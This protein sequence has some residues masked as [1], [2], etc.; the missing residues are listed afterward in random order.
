MRSWRR[1]L[2]PA[3]GSSVRSSVTAS[4]PTT[5]SRTA[6]IC[7]P[8][9]PST[10]HRDA[11]GCTTTTMRPGSAG[12]PAPTRGSSSCTPPT[13]R[14][15]AS[16]GS[17]ARGCRRLRHPPERPLAVIGAR[18]C[19]VRALDVLDRVLL[20]GDTP[21]PRYAA[22]RRGVFVVAVTCGVPSATCWCTSIG[23]GPQPAHG[24][25]LRLTELDDA[26]GHRLLVE[27]ATDRG[28]DV[29]A[30]LPG[31]AG[32][33]CRPRRR[34][35]RGRTRRRAAAAATA[36]PGPARAARGPGPPS[37]LGTT[38]R[39][40]ACRAATARWCARR[41]SARRSTTRPS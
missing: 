29:L 27:A 11:G 9:A 1:S 18:D 26:D 23:G 8:D 41:A 19:E 39:S 36:G 35:R 31:P 22:R 32:H 12:R 6:T 4:S 34:R 14:C 21:D 33:R 16:V 37:A 24:F 38:W 40:A 3:T 15:C 5:T 25:D 7:R 20:D 28:H 2:P 13:R 10:R 17:T 30:R